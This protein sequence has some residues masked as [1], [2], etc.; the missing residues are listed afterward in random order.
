MQPHRSHWVSSTDFVIRS[1]P[2]H[3]H[4]PTDFGFR[5][6][7]LTH[8]AHMPYG[9][10]LSFA[11]LTH[12]RLLPHTPSRA[13]QRSNSLWPSR[14]YPQQCTCL[15]SVGF[16]LSG[17]QVWTLTSYLL[18]MPVTLDGVNDPSTFCALHCIPQP[19]TLDRKSSTFR[20]E[21]YGLR[22]DSV[23]ISKQN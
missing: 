22:V 18:N 8:P 7:E 11:R 4:I 1:S 23:S 15:L 6:C 5:H 16:P 14:G 2:I 17:P 20:Y 19:A 10:S 21:G 12:L 9:A 3:M 13:S